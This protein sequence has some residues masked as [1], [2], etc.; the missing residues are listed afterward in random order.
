MSGIPKRI[1]FC[2]GFSPKAGRDRPWGLLN[3]ACVKSAVVRINP[4]YA[5]LYY[6][7]EQ[8]GPWWDLTKSLVDIQKVVAPRNIFGRPLSHAAH[9][10]DVFRLQKLLE[11]GGIYLDTDVLVL[12]DFT[13]L[14][15]NEC[16]L[17]NEGADDDSN[18]CNGVILALP[19][20]SFVK[21]WL[22]SYRSFRSVGRDKFWSEHSG[23]ISKQLALQFPN[24]V[25]ILDHKAFFWPLWTHEHLRWMFASAKDL[26]AP[27][28]YAH[29]LWEGRAWA[30][31]TDN[32][33]VKRVRRVDTNFHLLVRPLIEGLADDFAAPSWGSMSASQ[34]R[35]AIAKTRKQMGQLKRKLM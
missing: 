22:E 20:A 23:A 27:N 33:T 13:P 34:A 17:G 15:E 10:A 4:Q 6:E 24:E 7:H 9:R 21:R 14:L 16:V 19:N 2:S 26:D 12:R 3:Y 28:A 1:H 8:S 31:Y 5:S 32:L 35:K 25:T 29:H 11:E 30:E 18:I